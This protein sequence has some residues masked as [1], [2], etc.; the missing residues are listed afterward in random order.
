MNRKELFKQLNI[1]CEELNDKYNI[2]RGGCC[3]VAYCL[4][5]QLEIHNISFIAVKYGY[6]SHF[7]IKVSDR[8]L[9]RDDY[10]K[11]EITEYYSSSKELLD[12]YRHHRWNKTYRPKYNGCIK[13]I[14][15]TIFGKYDYNRT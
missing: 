7:S 13:R 1:L 9:N 14:I 4:A 11:R 3:Y 10:M 6:G 2:N 5:E 12:Y 15:K 8:Y